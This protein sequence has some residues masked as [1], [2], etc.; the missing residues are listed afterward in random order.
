MTQKETRT[1]KNCT[2]KAGYY[3]IVTATLKYL[4]V[5]NN[6]LV[7]LSKDKITP[8]KSLWEVE[9][10]YQTILHTFTSADDDQMLTFQN[11]T[12][13]FIKSNVQLIVIGNQM[14]E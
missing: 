11:N 3:Q 4:S 10:I 2:V 14:A 13:F 12:K 1:W 6:K 9:N 5:E 7:W 8:K